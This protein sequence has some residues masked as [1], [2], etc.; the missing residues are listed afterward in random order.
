M[1]KI[2]LKILLKLV[3]LFAGKH[4]DLDKLRIITETK[5]MMDRRR[6]PAAWKRNQKKEMKNPLLFTLI[7]YSIL[8]MFIGSL[9]FY[10]H[11]LLI[12][13][14][15]LHAY[16]LFMM[17]MT[18]ITDFSSVLLDTADN[19]IILPKP[20]NSRTLFLSRVIHILVY[21]LQFMIAIA[22]APII[23]T[24]IKYGLVTGATTLVTML[25][26]VTFA[27]FITYLLYALI[28]RFGNEQKIKD[29]IGYFQI[30]MTVFFAVGY[31]IIP[32]FIDFDNSNFT[33]NLHW[34]SYLLAPVWMGVTT[35]AV[36]QSIYDNVHLLMIACTITIPVV[37]T[38]LMVKFLAPS[39]SRKLAALNNNTEI[40]TTTKGE[41]KGR[42]DF[43]TKLT[44]I[45]CTSKTE[46][47]GFE[48]VW[49]IT[50]RDKSFKVQFYPSLAYLLVFAFVFVF[51]SGK[52]IS[53]IWLQLHTT[54]SFLWF[55][56]LPLMSISSCLNIIPFNENFA[57]AWIYQ[58]VPLAKPG[59]IISGT[60]K[61]LLV[62]F[63][64]PVYLAL[65]AF[66]FYVWGP[67]IIDD[68]VFGF[69]NNILIFV[70]MANLVDHY[71]PF[72]QQAN[73]K[74]Q[75]GKFVRVLIQ[76]ALVAVLIGLHYLA[77]NIYWLPLVLIPASAAAAFLLLKRI[78]H[79][80]WL[81][82]SI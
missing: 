41:R 55:V 49:K 32:R 26:T 30:F 67:M 61:A 6:S 76:L 44:A 24:F 53:D 23:F 71:L 47:A 82:I 36:H 25:L 5:I 17:A 13:M 11:S 81:K 79:L 63:F 64:I 50:A 4:I 33:F 28:L 37:T 66:A 8:G 19:Q 29:I 80:P 46:S 27:V 21:L 9:V 16:L 7:M 74:Q 43:S 39:F 18:L 31:Q 75:T 48:K 68:F 60:V 22:A 73:I 15:L 38:W 77:L 54:K 40:A 51:K 56:Y 57:A 12:C 65:F 34:Y 62:K 70:I 14:I 78:Q 52:N 58:T 3:K 72:S 42:K 10:L 1:D 69:F 35:E 20:V 59:E 45:F 2:L